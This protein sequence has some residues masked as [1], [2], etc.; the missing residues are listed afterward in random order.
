MQNGGVDMK[1]SLIALTFALMLLSISF[2]GSANYAKG[3]SE[4]ITYITLPSNS[5]PMGLLY[6]NNT[7]TVWVALH[8]NRSIA[9]I[10]VATKTYTLYRLPWD[11]GEE[12][13]GPLPWTLTLT[14]DGNL[15]F[16]ISGYMTNPNFPPAKGIPVLAKMNTSTGEFTI[17]WIPKEAGGGCD[18]K[19]HS[20]FVWYLTG[21]GLLKINYS[22]SSIV[23]F[24][25]KFIHGG[26]SMEIDDDFIWF[27]IT[28]DGTVTKFNTLTEDFETFVGFDRPLGIE[29]DNNYVY[30]AENTR[31]TG[32]NG[33]IARINKVTQKVD[34][35][36]TNTIV[37]NEG[38]FHVLKDSVGNLW[39]TTNSKQLGVKMAFTGTMFTYEAISPYCYFMTEVPE[40][41]IWFSAVGS[42]YIGITHPP[43]KSPDVN[44]DGI[45]DVF[46]LV[47]LANAY[48]TM[49]GDIEW[50]TACDINNDG[51]V[52]LFDLI[53]LAKGYGNTS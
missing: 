27:S 17:L 10:D 53:I 14:P 4:S 5:L 41:S 49:E 7:N 8:W 38:P 30:V 1:N 39:W 50:N 43:Y 2:I 15:W 26:G 9:K 46:D 44:N 22:S 24:Y 37:T 16:A 20:G 19:Y 32:V 31:N 45:V 52:D 11:V 12:Y 48:G 13:Y 40:G 18:I 29:I 42:A 21:Q 6:D 3:Q 34:R 51:L 36:E 25:A 47:T 33:T 23:N 28:E 35:I